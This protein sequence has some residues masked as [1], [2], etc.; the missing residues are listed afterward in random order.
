MLTNVLK[1]FK[2]LEN[3]DDPF[4]VRQR[5][6]ILI[7]MVCLVGTMQRSLLHP[8]LPGCGRHFSIL[9][10]PSLC[11]N[12]SV[13]KSLE[14]KDQCVCCQRRLSKKAKKKATLGSNLDDLDAES[15]NDEDSFDGN[16]S[17]NGDDMRDFI[18]DDKQFDS[19]SEEVNA[20]EDIKTK[21]PFQ[22]KKKFEMKAV[23]LKGMINGTGKVI[24]IPVQ[25]C[26]FAEKGINHFA[27]ESCI[28]TK[29]ER[30][31][32]CPMCKDILGRLQSNFVPHK[33]VDFQNSS[34]ADTNNL[35][36]DGASDSNEEEQIYCKN[37]FGGFK[38]TG[39]LKK[40]FS[41]VLNIPQDDKAM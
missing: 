34:D 25:Y 17:D 20:I 14:K 21:A 2:H 39:K 19:D 16:G 38:P 24:P 35:S 32:C 37:V 15:D 29:V 3:K 36:G 40:V 11:K 28:S 26:Q 30:E 41:D 7:Q 18:V 23:S 4:S 33:G 6:K 9:C 22:G 10:S 8:C 27:C 1:R 12:S 31:G 13:K 5:N